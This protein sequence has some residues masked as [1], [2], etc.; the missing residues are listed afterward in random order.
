MVEE[1]PFFIRVAASKVDFPEPHKGETLETLARVTSS[2][3]YVEGGTRERKNLEFPPE[4][5]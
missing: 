5:E 4:V 3:L 2:Y 1:D